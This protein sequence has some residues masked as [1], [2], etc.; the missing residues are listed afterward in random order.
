MRMSSGEACE[1]L[2]EA[3]NAQRTDILKSLLDHLV[4]GR[5]E[6]VTVAEVLPP[7]AL[8][9]SKNILQVLANQ[10]CQTGSLLHKAVEMG[11]RDAVRALLLAG[12]DPGLKNSSGETPIQV[13]HFC[14]PPIVFCFFLDG[15]TPNLPNIQRRVAESSGRIR[16]RESRAAA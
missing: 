14:F 10:C 2:L 12:A 6:G 5:A 9:Y 4:S 7:P 3:L 11:Q 16:P 13:D 15:W 1:S 8:K